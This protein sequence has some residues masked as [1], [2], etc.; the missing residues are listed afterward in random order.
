[1]K[2]GCAWRT[3][4]FAHPCLPPGKNEAGCSR[5]RP[6]T[7]LPA[8]LAPEGGRRNGIAP[9]ET[10]GFSPRERRGG[11]LARSAAPVTAEWGV[12]LPRPID[13]LV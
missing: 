5:Y 9:G 8:W 6:L 11:R 4:L 7:S 13:E 2:Q 12:A 10:N 1:M 3:P